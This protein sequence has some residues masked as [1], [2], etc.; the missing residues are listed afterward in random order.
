MPRG[1]G[2]ARGGALKRPARKASIFVQAVK[3]AR[4]TTARGDWDEPAA[5][6]RRAGRAE[7]G[8][9]CWG[10]ACAHARRHTGREAGKDA[11]RR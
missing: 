1:A 3:R 8:G 10:G 4:S 2:T 7:E 9:G 11:G 5:A 6:E